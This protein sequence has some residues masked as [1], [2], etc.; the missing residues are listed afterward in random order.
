M[1]E[2]GWSYLVN[3]KIYFSLN[4]LECLGFLQQKRN[5]DRMSQLAIEQI[6][7]DLPPLFEIISPLNSFD[8]ESIVNSKFLMIIVNAYDLANYEFGGV[9][10]KTKN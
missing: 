8:T 10:F 9:L 3:F 4:C 7:G 2:L 6:E 5:V 1:E